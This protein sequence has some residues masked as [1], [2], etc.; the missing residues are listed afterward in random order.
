M[1]I[2]LVP[3]IFCPA[4]KL[5]DAVRL[6]LLFGDFLL[7]NVHLLSQ[8]SLLVFVVLGQFLKAA[9]IDFT[10]DIVLVNSLEQPV[11]F[12]NPALRLCELPAFCGQLF[13]E[14]FLAFSAEF[15]PEQVFAI[16]NVPKQ[17]L[18][19]FQHTLFQ[20]NCAD[21]VRTAHIFPFLAG[22][23]ADKVVLPLFKVLGGTVV[24]LFPAVGTVGN[25]GK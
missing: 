10:R 7:Q 25:A 9:V 8:L 24:H 16:R 19:K 20:N 3:G 4:D 5:L 21:E 22:C 23:R 15:F 1:S 6:F 12:F 2:P 17:D 11:E 18:Q 14:I 13:F